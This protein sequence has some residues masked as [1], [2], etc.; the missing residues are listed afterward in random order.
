MSTV[1]PGFSQA[2]STVDSSLSAAQCALH[3]GPWTEGMRLPRNAAP[4]LWS[5]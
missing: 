4:L 1:A 5:A 3:R 2:W